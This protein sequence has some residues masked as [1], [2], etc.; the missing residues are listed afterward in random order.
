MSRR[1]SHASWCPPGNLP[2]GIEGRAIPLK[3]PSY[4][5]EL[6]PHEVTRRGDCYAREGIIKRANV[7]SRAAS[8]VEDSGW[9]F[10][11]LQ[12]E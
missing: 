11:L 1:H 6:F 2:Q 8:V 4:S 7:V 12:D 10:F 9:R 5:E 3:G